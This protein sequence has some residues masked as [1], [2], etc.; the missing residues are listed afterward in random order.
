MLRERPLQLPRPL[1]S[2]W[3]WQRNA[4][5]RSVDV[6]VFYDGE[7]L[8]EV[9][10]KA[11]CA[12]CPVIEECRDYAVAANEPHG[13]WGGLSPSE[14][15]QYRWRQGVVLRVGLTRQRTL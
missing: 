15:V 11:I 1:I 12:D 9:A 5:C 14:R 13:I 4:R 10:A 8:S 3:D 2:E 7:T 6:D